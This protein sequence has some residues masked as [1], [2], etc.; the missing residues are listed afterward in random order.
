MPTWT[1]PPQLVALAAFFAQAQAQP[2]TIGD[3]V[4]LDRWQEAI[5]G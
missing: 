5:D 4:F 2:D 1:S 3:A